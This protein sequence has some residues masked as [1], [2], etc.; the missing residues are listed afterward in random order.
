MSELLQ[1]M[2]RFHRR[3][4]LCTPLA[5]FGLAL[6]EPFKVCGGQ[7]QQLTGLCGAQVFDRSPVQQAQPAQQLSGAMALDRAPLLAGGHLGQ[8][9]YTAALDQPDAWWRCAWFEDGFTCFVG[10]TFAAIK[11]LLLK[12]DLS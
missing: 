5:E 3:G 6:E 10:A 9:A 12:R 8:A 11:Q 2:H 7:K 1:Q 4:L